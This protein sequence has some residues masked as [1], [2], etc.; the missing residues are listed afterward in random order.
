MK[1][2]LNSPIMSE[3]LNSKY[4]EI[5]TVKEMKHS[6]SN[7]KPF[8]HLALD[9]FLKPNKALE[10][11]NALKKALTA[12]KDSEILKLSSI[13][14]SDEGILKDYRNFV[15]SK[16][17]ISYINFITKANILKMDP[18]FAYKYQNSDF[19][20]CHHDYSRG[21]KITFTLYLSD[22]EKADG[23]SLN[24]YSSKNNQP[25]KIEKRIVPKF[26]KLVFYESTKN[27]FHETE[28]VFGNKPRYNISCGFS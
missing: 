27:N 12:R 26:N 5:N 22:M 9:N 28:K 24:L 21:R 3:C 11:L 18:L 15:S 8:R 6:F 13:L 1:E 16:E 17:L 25:L 2:F 14:I 19:F 10:I 7:I 20:S 23:G 4:L